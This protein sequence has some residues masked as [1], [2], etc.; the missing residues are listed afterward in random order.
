M[1]NVLEIVLAGDVI[2]ML[3]VKNTD[4]FAYLQVL[5]GY[6]NITQAQGVNDTN[7]CT[8]NEDTLGPTSLVKLLTPFYYIPLVTTL[9]GAGIWIR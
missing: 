5:P 6:L 8:D 3:L 4:Q 2:I 9:L 1:S 7:S